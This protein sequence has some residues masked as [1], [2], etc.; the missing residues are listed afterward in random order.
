MDSAGSELCPVADFGT[1]GVELSVFAYFKSKLLRHLKSDG[2]LLL[3]LEISEN[4]S[5]I[6]K[7]V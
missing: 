5:T 3:G 7:L 6:R 1:V 4:N 2:Q